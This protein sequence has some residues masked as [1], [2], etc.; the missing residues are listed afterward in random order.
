MAGDKKKHRQAGALSDP[1]GLEPFLTILSS[2]ISVLS[3]AYQFGLLSTRHRRIRGNFSRMRTEVLRLHNCLDDLVLA[4]Q[5]HSQFA[6]LHLGQDPR[7]SDR[8]ATLAE[9]LLELREADYLRWRDLQDKIQTLAQAIYRLLSDT[10]RLVQELGDERLVETLGKE[11]FSLVDELL[12][13]LGNVSFGDFV[14]G[15]R[16]VLAKLEETLTYVVKR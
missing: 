9:T 2:A 14:A 10:R 3:F 4:L 11:V 6:N 5:R 13:G 8:K 1:I 12:I 16:N 15:L 7:A